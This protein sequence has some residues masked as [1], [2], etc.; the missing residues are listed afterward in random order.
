M[1]ANEHLQRIA[2][3]GGAWLVL[4]GGEATVDQVVSE[5]LS[6]GAIGQVKQRHSFG[7]VTV[8]RVIHSGNR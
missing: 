1:I 5:L 4:R 7:G 2:E 3:H 6:G 8:I